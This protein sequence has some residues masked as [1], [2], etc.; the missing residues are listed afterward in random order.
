MQWGKTFVD[1]QSTKILSVA[2]S[3]THVNDIIAAITDTGV[4]LLIDSEGTFLT[5]RQLML[6]V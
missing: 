2:F 3:L 1:Q 4:V 5:S 6:S